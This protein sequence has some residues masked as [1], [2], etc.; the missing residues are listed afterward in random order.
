LWF[1]PLLPDELR[2]LELS[3]R[4]RNH[5]IGVHVDHEALELRS[6]PGPAGPVV[7][8]LREDCYELAPGDVLRLELP[9]PA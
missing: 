2:R 9:A 7:V 5:M 3:L 6:A 4:Y 8:G 1:N